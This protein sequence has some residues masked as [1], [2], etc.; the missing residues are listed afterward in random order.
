MYHGS[1]LIS[2]LDRAATAILETLPPAM[3]SVR[4]QMR[5]GRAASLSVPQFRILLFVRRR[6][7]SNLSAVAEQLGV[8]LPAASQLVRRLVRAGLLDRQVR[9]EERRHIEL[10]LTPTGAGALTACDDRTRAWLLARLEGLTQGQLEA[11]IDALGNLRCILGDDPPGARAGGPAV[12]D[13]G[14]RGQSVAPETPESP[15]T[16]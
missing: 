11:L 10:R 1:V 4:A 8:S 13:M 5:S 15:A 14:S 16:F 7:G 9:P 6:P 12:A 2:T 3:R